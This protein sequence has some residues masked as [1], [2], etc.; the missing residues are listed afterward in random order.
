MASKRKRNGGLLKMPAAQAMP[1]EIRQ[2]LR[3]ELG[4]D[5][6]DRRFN[7]AALRR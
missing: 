7:L 4:R 5:S 3:E 1:D 6:R 2:A